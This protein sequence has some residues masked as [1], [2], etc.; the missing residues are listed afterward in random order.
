MKVTI[1]TTHE[2]N[3]FKNDEVEFQGLEIK[4]YDVYNPKDAQE[5]AKLVQ[6]ALEK[7][8]KRE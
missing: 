7:E 8:K 3:Q 6:E 5:L 1:T 2:T 4:A